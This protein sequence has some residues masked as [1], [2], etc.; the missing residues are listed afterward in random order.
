MG[1]DAHSVNDSSRRS[2]GAAA[3]GAAQPPTPLRYRVGDL[4]VDLGLAQVSRGEHTIPLP[5][6]SFDLLV[7]L[8]RAAPNLVSQDSLMSTVWVG[9][10]VSP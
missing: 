8:L 5:K 3:T 4:I 6:L 7:A 9:L 10:V 1:T 2:P